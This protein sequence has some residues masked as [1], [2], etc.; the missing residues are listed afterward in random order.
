MKKYF[1]L[2]LILLITV[3]FSGF[4]QIKEKEYNS[5]KLITVISL[6]TVGYTVSMIGLYKLWFSDYPMSTFHIF[7]DNDGWESID[8]CGHTLTSYYVGKIGM[9]ALNWAGVKRNKAIW[10]GGTLGLAFMTSVEIFDGYSDGWGA[11]PGDIIANFTGAGLLIGQELLWNEQRLKL[12]FSDHYSEFQKYNPDVLGHSFAE[13]MLKDYNGHTNWYSLNVKSFLQEESKFPKWLN[14]AFGYGA[15]GLLAGYGNPTE[16]DGKPVPHFEVYKQFY[17]AP[18]I[19]LS[20]IE[21]NSK[22]LKILFSAFGFIKF[23]APTL[24]YNKFDNLKFHWLYF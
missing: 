3:I 14:F 10:Y 18:D 7:N 21:T 1:T 5:K 23:P 17:F 15:D 22:I 24:E 9:E 16:V 6:E 20:K 19:D 12:K 13:R 8:K 4:S 11:S 2:T